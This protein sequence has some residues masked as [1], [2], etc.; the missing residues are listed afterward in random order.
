M[1]LEHS[2]HWSPTLTHRSRPHPRY[3]RML[4]HRVVYVS[5]AEY[6][7]RAAMFSSYL[8]QLRHECLGR[9]AGTDDAADGQQLASTVG[10]P[11]STADGQRPSDSAAAAAA[12][13][14]AVSEGI[15][16]IPEGAAGPAALLGLIRQVAWLAGS[17]QSPLRS[18][19]SSSSSAS[20]D[21]ST[22]WR[23]VV[24][25]GTGATATGTPRGLVEP[26]CVELVCASAC[27]SRCTH[28][29][30]LQRL[31]VCLLPF[32]QALLWVLPCWACHGELLG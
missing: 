7:D 5:R 12:E 24:D 32:P 10:Q 23:L 6:A 11:R 8:Q 15:A 22:T 13:E 1:H 16:V 27:R 9:A 4:A 2:L 29:V 19:S 28:R 3:A 20:S 18:S 21:T 14:W 30:M 31:H 25:S 26:P 17:P